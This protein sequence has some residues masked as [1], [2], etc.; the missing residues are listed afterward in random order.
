MEEKKGWYFHCDKCQVSLLDGDDII[1]VTVGIM[2]GN[3]PVLGPGLYYHRECFRQMGEE[4][5]VVFESN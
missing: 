2:S 1:A 3:T 4:Q 5:D